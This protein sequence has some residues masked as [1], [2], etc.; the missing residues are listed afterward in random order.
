MDLRQRHALAYNLANLMRTLATP[1]LIEGWSLTDLRERL[2]KIRTRLVPHGRYAIFQMA[3]AALPQEVFAGIPG[4][5]NTL[6]GPPAV[7]GVDMMGRHSKTAKGIAGGETGAP[8]NRRNDATS[9]WA[10]R[11]VVYYG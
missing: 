7:A 1:E 5:I 9:S 8:A 11:L 3:A 10:T 2:I 4:L 6:R